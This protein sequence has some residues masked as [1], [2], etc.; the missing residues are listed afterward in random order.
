[1]RLTISF[2]LLLVGVFCIAVAE[3]LTLGWVDAE[4][5]ARDCWFIGGVL[6]SFASFLPWPT[7]QP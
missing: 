2:V 3:L 5:N 1:M 7:S 4:G 6:M